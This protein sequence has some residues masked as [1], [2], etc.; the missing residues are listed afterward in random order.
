M[1][2]VSAGKESRVSEKP[3]IDPPTGPLSSDDVLDIK[4]E[5]GKITLPQIKF[6]GRKK[7][8]TRLASPRINYR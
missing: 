2:A 5:A 7:V 6:L 1:F 4:N 8:K 3:V